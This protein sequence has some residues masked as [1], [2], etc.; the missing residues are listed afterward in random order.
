M[1]QA[2]TAHLTLW[3]KNQ[4]NFLNISFKFMEKRDIFFQS[5]LLGAPKTKILERNLPQ[6]SSRYLWVNLVHEFISAFADRNVC[7]EFDKNQ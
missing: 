2:K 6:K 1:S 4:N 3:I 7:V 5:N